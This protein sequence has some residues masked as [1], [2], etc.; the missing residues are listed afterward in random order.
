MPEVPSDKWD[1]SEEGKAAARELRGGF[2]SVRAYATASDEPKAIQTIDEIAEETPV[3]DRDFGEVR[4]PYVWLNYTGQDP[5]RAYVEGARHEGWERQE[6]VA[7]RFEAAVARHAEAAA[8]SNRTLVVGT[9]GMAL[10]LWLASRIQLNPDPVT[11]WIGLRFPDVIDVDLAAG[12]VK[13]W[14]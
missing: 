10:T 9:H 14:Q 2:S 7:A 1:L 6:E 3:V 4:R 12:T 5:N 8:N 13:T 11:F